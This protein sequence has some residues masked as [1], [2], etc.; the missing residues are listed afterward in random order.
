MLRKAH[1]GLALHNSR[2]PMENPI[3]PLVI[4]IFLRFTVLVS[5]F[6]GF[7]VQAQQ[8]EVVSHYPSSAYITKRL[9]PFSVVGD[10]Q[11][12][13]QSTRLTQGD[14]CSSILDPHYPT[15]FH[16][17]CERPTRVRVELQ[18]IRA[19]QQTFETSVGTFEVREQSEPRS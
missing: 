12:R 17:Y 7:R 18:V 10:E 15:T 13:I 19:S 16:I 1:L 5:L 2:I 9:I 4:M 6:F 11:A 3:S 8:L 14:S